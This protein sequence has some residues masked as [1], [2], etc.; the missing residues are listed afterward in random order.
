MLA[1]NEG[2]TNV[3]KRQRFA[4]GNGDFGV[5]VRSRPLRQTAGRRRGKAYERLAHDE[6]VGTSGAPRGDQVGI[7]WTEIAAGEGGEA[8]VESKSNRIEIEA[9]LEGFRL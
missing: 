5:G 8:K 9:K 6:A 4:G 2:G 3:K 1:A 7:N